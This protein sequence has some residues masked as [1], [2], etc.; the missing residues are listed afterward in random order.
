MRSARAAKAEALEAVASHPLGHPE[1]GGPTRLDALGEDSANRAG[2]PPRVCRFCLV[3]EDEGGDEDG[4]GGSED[5]DGDGRGARGVATTSGKR[6]PCSRGRGWF[7][8][9]RV[10]RLARV[11]A[12]KLLRPGTRLRDDLLV[13]PCACAGSQKWVHVGCL[14][15]WTRVSVSDSGAVRNRCMVCK[16]RYS[17]AVR[18]VRGTLPDALS[19][20][21]RPTAAD[22][23]SGYERAWWQMLTNTIVAQEGTPTIATPSQLAL[24]VVAVEVRIWGGREARGGNVVLRFLRDAARRCTNA[25]SV[26][27]LAWLA[28]VGAVSVGDALGRTDGP[29][30]QIIHSGRRSRS[31]ARAEGGARGGGGGGGR[32]GWHAAAAKAAKA[33]GA[34][35]G[36]ALRRFAA[37]GAGAAMRLAE[38]AQSVITWVER[39]PQYRV[40]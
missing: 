24:V 26:V 6:F 37:P 9:P 27:L 38:P 10:A 2:A 1:D 22:R 12:S 14:R 29:L 31:E 20:W 15:R 32:P 23:L 33:L 21:F 35:L 40:M 25:H 36:F 7:F 8:F 39:Y 13:A 34:P 5:Q 17:R 16:R 28:C 30:D 4:E 11:F 3:G 18:G 19:R